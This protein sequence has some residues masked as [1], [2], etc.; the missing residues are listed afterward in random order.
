MFLAAALAIAAEGAIRRRL[1]H[2]LPEVF[3]RAMCYQPDNSTAD[4]GDK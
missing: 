4:P 1:P 3:S 2:A